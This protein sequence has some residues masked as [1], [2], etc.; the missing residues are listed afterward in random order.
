MRFDSFQHAVALD[1]LSL[2][3]V[4]TPLLHQ[5]R[6]GLD[7]AVL[8]NRVEVG[9]RVSREGDAADDW[10]AVPCSGDI[11]FMRV[12]TR[13]SVQLQKTLRCWLQLNWFANPKNFLDIERTVQIV[14]Y[15]ACKPFYPKAKEGYAYDLL[16][17]WSTN[18]IQRSLKTDMPDV[19]ARVSS[20]LRILGIHELADFYDP[21]HAAWFLD[22]IDRKG[23]LFYEI[24][25]R[26]AKIIHTW[27]PLIGRIPSEKE[28]LQARHATSVALN[29]ILRRGEDLSSLGPLFEMETLAAIEAHIGKPASRKL[30]LTGNPV[31]HPESAAQPVRALAKVLSFPSQRERIDP[32]YLDKAA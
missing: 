28:L 11:G 14:A 29:E 7:E 2:T 6:T 10:T 19:L 26:E 20:Q 25:A 24:L 13:V 18:S 23:H 12:A 16:D 9:L 30:E 8:A 31:K 15:L 21:C 5:Y 4:L 27:V 1:A 32:S 22:Q 3:S 17:D